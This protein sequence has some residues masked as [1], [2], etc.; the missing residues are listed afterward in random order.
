MNN[1]EKERMKLWRQVYV[2][3]VNRGFTNATNEAD[4]AVTLFDDK[5]SPKEGSNKEGE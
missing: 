3:K 1:Y 5:F 2:S 4:L